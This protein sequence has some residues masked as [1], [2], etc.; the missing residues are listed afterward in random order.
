MVTPVKNIIFDLGGVLINLNYQ[1]TR[2]AFEDLGVED[3]DAF[4][5][6]HK[7][8]PLFENLEV[9]AIEPEAFYEALREATGLTLSNDQL[10]TA[11]NAMLLDFPIERL[12]W[13]D[14]IKNKYN[15]YLF[16]NTN[17][18]HYKAF[19]SIYAQTAPL[20]GLNTDF[21]HF[22][23]TAYYSHTLGQ[24]KPELAAFEA[25]IQD[26]KLDPAQTLFIDDTISNIEGAQKAGLRTIFLS[27]GL[28]VQDVGL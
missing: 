7:V 17:A 1:L 23:K 9:G 14:Q 15:I 11:W 13:L 4:Y 28:N 21:N 18:I 6:Q 24:R 12:L 3:F 19:T 27:G 22:F 5:T 25:V 16:S 8:N 2:K 10:E 20:I 26:A